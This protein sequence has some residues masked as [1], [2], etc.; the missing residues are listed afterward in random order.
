LDAVIDVIPSR[1]DK[2]AEQLRSQGYGNSVKA[3]DWESVLADHS[4]TAI[5]LAVE[6]RCLRHLIENAL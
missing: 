4:I 2:A 1:A 6:I 3:R 5:V